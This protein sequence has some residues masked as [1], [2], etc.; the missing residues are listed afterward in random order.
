[1]SK[2]AELEATKYYVEKKLWKK[3]TYNVMPVSFLKCL[4]IESF[5]TDSILTCMN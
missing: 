4:F 3:N 2:C 5:R 1:M